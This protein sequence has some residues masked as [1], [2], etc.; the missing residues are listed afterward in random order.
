MISGGC[1]ANILTMLEMGFLSQEVPLLFPCI[2][3]IET[4]GMNRQISRVFPRDWLLGCVI[5]AYSFC[6]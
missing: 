5:R 3:Y 1:A 2:Q 4:D 6:V